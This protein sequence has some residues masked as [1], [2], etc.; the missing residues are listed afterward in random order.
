MIQATAHQLPAHFSACKSISI[1]AHTTCKNLSSD[2]LSVGA[3]LGGLLGG[4]EIARTRNVTRLGRARP[5]VLVSDTAGRAA[6]CGDIVL[7]K[8]LTSIIWRQNDSDEWCA[9]R[10]G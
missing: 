1:I 10:W 6:R 2:V 3:P 9:R 5:T 8:V 4:S 7:E